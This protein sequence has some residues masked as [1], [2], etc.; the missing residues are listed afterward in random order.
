LRELVQGSFHDDRVRVEKEKNLAGS[1]F[2]PEIRSRRVAKV[3]SGLQDTDEVAFARFL[4][5]RA[6]PAVVDDDRLERRAAIALR[7]KR[8]ET[9]RERG[10]AVE[11]DDDDGNGQAAKAKRLLRRAKRA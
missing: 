8:V 1:S 6:V 2:G 5:L 9:P 10:A 7:S 11:G 4:D 3:A